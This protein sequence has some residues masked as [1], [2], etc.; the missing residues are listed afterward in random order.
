MRQRA[1][2]S[3]KVL[4]HTPRFPGN[5]PHVSPSFKKSPEERSSRSNEV[6]L[7]RDPAPHIKPDP[8]M[9]RK[10]QLRSAR[11]EAR[12]RQLE[13]ELQ[14]EPNMVSESVYQNT[15]T[16][17]SY[18]EDVGLSDSGNMGERHKRG[19]R[20]SFKLRGSVVERLRLGESVE[21]PK[22]SRINEDR[23]ESTIKPKKRNTVIK[24]VN[25]NVTIPSV[26]S[27]GNLSRLLGV[28]LG[29]F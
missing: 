21:I 4:A 1:R 7:D 29:R 25:P 17:A 6:S 19:Q 15:R 26:V 3:D 8:V 11:T 18:V 12:D 9:L 14:P 16:R 22:H 20:D 27:V 23:L 24:P 13:R 5:T 28:R 2:T 10:E